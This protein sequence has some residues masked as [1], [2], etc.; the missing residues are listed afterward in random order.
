VEPDQDIERLL[1]ASRPH[2]R[3][4]FV[5]QTERALLESRRRWLRAPSPALRLGTALAC[6]LAALVL[7]LSL[8]GVGP[9]AGSDE[10]VQAQDSCRTVAVT[11]LVNQPMIVAG[12][13]GEAKV[14][15]AKRP[16]QRFVRRCR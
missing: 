6:G 9:L 11:R 4:A 16:Q 10:G 14:V 2:P 13:H 15:Y 5:A 12:K 8:A 3:M 7:A 1:R